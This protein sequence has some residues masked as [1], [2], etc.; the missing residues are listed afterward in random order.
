MQQIVKTLFLST[1]IT[2]T[3]TPSYAFDLSSL[4]GSSNDKSE[5]ATQA[6]SL[7]KGVTNGQL[8]LNGV[9]NQINNSLTENPLTKMLSSGLG[10]SGIQAAGGAGAMLAM[11]S[12][13]LPQNQSNELL[14]MIPQMNSLTSM[15][16]SNLIGNLGSIASVDKAFESLGLNTSMIQQFAPIIVNYL[17]SQGSSNVLTSALQKLWAA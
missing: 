16:P 10:I 2:A 14:K 5:S 6:D 8:D 1:L 13:S 3:A 7:I 15:L 4:F 11:A 12:Q 9:K 17:S